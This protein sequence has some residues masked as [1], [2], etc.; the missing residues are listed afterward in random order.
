MTRRPRRV[1]AHNPQ[2]KKDRSH[3]RYILFKKL[4]RRRVPV[5]SKKSSR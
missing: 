4:I 2:E 5:E 1:P 3:N